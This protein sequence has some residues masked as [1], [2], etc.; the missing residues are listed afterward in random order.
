MKKLHGTMA[1]LGAAF[2][3][4]L[5]WK[6][7]AAELWRGIRGLGWALVPLILSE[8]A[9]NLAH[10]AGWRRCLHPE[11]RDLRLFT[12]FRVSMAGFAINY[13]TPSASLGGEVTKAAWL[14]SDRRGEPAVSSVLL[15]KGC[16][17]LGHLLLVVIGSAVVL[18]RMELPAIL[19]TVM[20]VSTLLLSTGIGIFIW[21]QKEGRMGVIVR[22]LAKRGL[23]GRGLREAAERI[24]GVDERL[25]SFHRDRRRDLAISTWWHFVGHAMALLQTWYFFR[26]L[27]QPVVLTDVLCAAILCLWFDLLTFAIP[28]NLGAMEGSRML[29]LKQVGYTGLQGMT[30]GAA[31]RIA[32]LFWA[33][34]G[35]AGYGLFVWSQGRNRASARP[36]RTSGEL[37]SRREYGKPAAGN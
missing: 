16:V 37:P 17:A 31:L 27:D 36:A 25:K 32:Q 30:Y 22:W 1:A 26:L 5:V 19:Q 8:G 3:V 14:A 35:L 23:G 13:L 24:S 34:F 7:G 9:A 18:W 11:H 15:D 33:G 29:A 10:T 6:V 2:L 4:Y 20:V 28:L 12:L 21:L